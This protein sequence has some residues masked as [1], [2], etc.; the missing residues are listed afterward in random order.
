LIEFLELFG[1]FYELMVV[2]FYF[3]LKAYV[4]ADT[5]AVEIFLA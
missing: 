1:E 5:L 4:I 2:F 3:N